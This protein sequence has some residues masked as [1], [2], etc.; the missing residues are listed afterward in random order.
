MDMRYENPPNTIGH[1]IGIVKDLAQKL[2]TELEGVTVGTALNLNDG[3]RFRDEIVRYEVDLI[4]AA[5]RMTG[6][7]QRHAAEMLGIKATTLNC[8]IKKY[9]IL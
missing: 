8:K 9:K 5:L 1:R 4:R 7:H 6:N 2:M 3:I